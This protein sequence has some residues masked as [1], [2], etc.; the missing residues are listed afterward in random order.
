M[1]E[2]FVYSPPAQLP[3][4]HVDKDI[5]VVNK[6]SGLL[7]VPGREHQD[8]ALTRLEQQ[9]GDYD[10]HRLDMD[11][12]GLLLFALRRNAERALKQQPVSVACPSTTWH[13]FT[14]FTEDRTIDLPLMRLDVHPPRSVVDSSGKAAQTEVSGSLTTNASYC[15]CAQSLGAHTSGVHSSHWTPNCWRRCFGP[16]PA[17]GQ[18]VCRLS[19]C[20]LHILG[21]GLSYDL[22][23]HHPSGL[24]ALKYQIRSLRR[25]LLTMLVT[26]GIF[27]SS[28]DPI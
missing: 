15:N 25:N 13:W 9:L 16:Q 20:A 18:L 27:S 24:S 7:S 10:V 6:P 4:V 23:L 2:P 26:S 1:E 19:S 5:V 28:A 3:I 21:V 14:V 8:S 11:T 12:S 22:L 17:I